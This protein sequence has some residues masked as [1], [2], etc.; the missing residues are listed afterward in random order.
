MHNGK[1]LHVTTIDLSGPPAYIPQ[2]VGR[3]ADRVQELVAQTGAGASR[4][5]A[6]QLTGAQVLT[7]DADA[8]AAAC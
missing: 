5:G 6:G 3:V 8:A 2:D 7:A 4:L 1:Q